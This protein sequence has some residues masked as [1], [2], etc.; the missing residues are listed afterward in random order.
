MRSNYKQ[1]GQ[2]I[3]P[4]SLKNKS[5]VT[6][7]LI[8]LSTAKKFRKPT[9]NIV[10]TDLSKYKL[11]NTNQ[12]V[13][14][15]VT[16]TWK[17]LA[18][19]LYNLK[20]PAIVSPV[21]KVFEIIDNSQ[22]L[23]EYLML[24]FRRPEIDRYAR[25]KSHGSARE[26]FDWDEMCATELP[27]PSIEKQREIVKEY[28]TI[29][30]RITLNEQIN[31]KLEETAQALYKHWFVDFEFPNEDGKPYKSSGGEM[32]FNEELDQEIPKFWLTNPISSFCTITS[33]K[34]IFEYE[35][36]R[37]GIP[38]FRAGEI[39]QKKQGIPIKDALFISERRYN[40]IVSKFGQP[41]DGDILLTA[42]GS[43]LGDSYLVQPEKFYFKD[44]N[45][46]W[47]KDFN[48]IDYNIY[49]YGFLQSNYFQELLDEIRI[50]SGQSAI[51]I[52]GL[53]EKR[54]VTP[55]E[56]ILAYYAKKGNLIF[57]QI[58]FRNKQ[59]LLLHELK[60]I[61]LSK[62]SKAETLQALQEI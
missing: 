18:V 14:M 7:N 32:V 34:R 53:G 38:F 28:N 1:L 13:Y 16:D 52:K 9:S 45:V 3:R 15:P 11:V 37:E 48:Q 59:N 2:F 44:G 23:P 10:G 27:V 35:Y 57:K 46:V 43:L 55:K 25:F 62:I 12:F 47:F 30:N 6:T 61:T 20:L 39:K 58:A 19:A 56:D 17:G 24:W 29:V 41:E 21:Y 33:S 36:V 22:L 26:T 5:L 49:I 51:T 4:I 8:G 31:Q 50:G 42:V 54:V 40:E 60:E